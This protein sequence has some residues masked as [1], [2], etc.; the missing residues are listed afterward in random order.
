MFHHNAQVDPI[1][2]KGQNQGAVLLLHGFTGTPDSMR[3]LANHVHALGFTVSVPLLAGHGTT[4]ESLS[5]TG[6]KDWYDSASHA[7]LELKEKHSH[8]AVCGLSL[9][10]LLTLR[11]AEDYPQAI[12]AIACLATP[13]YLKTWAQLLVP[14]V[15]QT[16]LANLYPYQKKFSV[17]VKDP[18]AKVNYWN[19]EEMP[20]SCVNSIIKLQTAVRQDLGK[21][22][23]PTLLIHSRYDSTAPYGSMGDIARR[24]AA[25]VTETV[26]LENSFHLVTLDYEKE[27][28]AQRVGLFFSRFL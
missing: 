9:G 15:A 28:V 21:I 16:P 12:H 13:L 10:G 24:I 17:D 18:Q 11:L 23:A 4:K 2:K 6:W 20:V 14:L 7:F 25:Q 22:T 1:Y 5:K 3:S 19:I 8:I 27:A 26:T